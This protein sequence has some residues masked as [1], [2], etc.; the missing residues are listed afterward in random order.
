MDKNYV[1]I[2][3]APRSGTTAI[4][5]LLNHHPSIAIGIERYKNVPSEQLV[6]SVF[7]KERFFDFRPTDTNVSFVKH[8]TRL[9]KK[10]DN[11]S[12][13]GDKVPRY[14]TKYDLLLR[15]FPN[16]KIGYMLRHIHPLASSWNVRADEPTDSWPLANDYRRAVEDWNTSIGLTLRFLERYPDQLFV[17]EYERLFSGDEDVLQAVFNE[18][19]I[20]VPDATV[21]YFRKLT[22]GWADRSEKKLVKKP[23]QDEYIAA[24]ANWT[25]Y[26][27]LLDHAIPRQPRLRQGTHAS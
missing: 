3:G 17:V 23:G 20:T 6:P 24:N 12:W 26:Q 27:S 16:C 21:V 1:F 5:K 22:E 11:V 4:T 15:N 25:Q 19:G 8:Y 9:A 10:F 13:V 14:Y 7:T 18:L 2:C